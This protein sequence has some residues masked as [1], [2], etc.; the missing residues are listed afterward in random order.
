MRRT[1]HLFFVLG[2]T[3]DSLTLSFLASRITENS[4]GSRST[5]FWQNIGSTGSHRAF[6]GLASRSREG[7]SMTAIRT[8][9]GNSRDHWVPQF[10]LRRWITGSE[11][12]LSAF[13][14]ESGRERHSRCSPRAV[15]SENHLYSVYGVDGTFMHGESLIFKDIDTA[16][17]PAFE[18]LADGNWRE[19]PQQYAEPFYHFI[20]TLAP[21]SR[22]MRER[23]IRRDEHLQLDMVGSLRKMGLPRADEE[24]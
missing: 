7:L 20:H 9:D 8:D 19:L 2:T 23:F 12:K 21:R 3:A 6:S 5:A 17:A 24:V 15:L 16:A 4:Q 11:K 10:Y 14:R 1:A 13:W 22:G 18:Y